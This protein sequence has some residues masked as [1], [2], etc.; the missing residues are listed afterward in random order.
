MSEALKIAD[1][2]WRQDRLRLT[3][4]NDPAHVRVARSFVRA[5][6]E[7]YGY[8]ARDLDNWETVI[9]EAVSNV[10][11][12]AYAPAERASFD[13]DCLLDTRGLTVRVRD[14]GRPFAPRH[15]LAFGADHA[16]V[17][18]RGLG[19]HL[20]QRLMDVVT[21]ESLGR[22]GKQ[23]TLYKAAPHKL[24][25]HL[26]PSRPSDAMSALA[27]GEKVVCRKAT[28]DDAD[29]VIR[30]FYDCYRYSYFNEQVYSPEALGEMISRGE[31]DSFVAEAPGGRI[32]AHLAL[33]HCRERPNALE[34]GMGATDPACRGRGLIEQLS[35]FVAE[36]AAQSGKRVRFGGAVTAHVASQKA[37]HRLGFSECG[38]M[39]GAVP[40]ESFTG[41]EVN[42]Q[43]RGTI[44]FLAHLQAPR[45]TP[46]VFLPQQH[47]DFISGLY[48]RSHIAFTPG[49][50][51][52]PVHQHTDISISVRPKVGVVRATVQGIGSDLGERIRTMMH[53]ARLGRTEVGQL[54]LP[55][56]DPALPQAVT[57]LEGMGWFVTGMM[58][59][60][61]LA[62]DALLMH[63]LNGWAVDYDKIA[64]GRDEG[65]RLV[66]DI[67]M[68]DP[69]WR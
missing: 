63:W 34:Y 30:L 5:A 59:E 53:A 31:I 9:E 47:E 8:D 12:H 28:A 19:W 40:A 68:R 43:G 1:G 6:A 57:L 7:R 65:R 18:Q 29:Q 49:V 14:R 11:R 52:S 26:L 51:A 15:H 62:G 27:A 45:P 3:L 16:S 60:G 13:I 25:P 21:V 41:L 37:L 2:E 64:M 55:L 10:I 44:V 4:P 36:P 56:T 32:V 67:R 66:E 38:L 61:G 33:E 20:M 17:P 35:T 58:P 50:P 69:E 46:T 22:E 39:L 24:A 23:L 42:D 54:F 48:S